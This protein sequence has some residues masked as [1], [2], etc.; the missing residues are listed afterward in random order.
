[1]TVLVAKGMK[2]LPG[3]GDPMVTTLA[4][5]LLILTPLAAFLVLTGSL[6]PVNVPALG[7]FAAAGVSNMM[8]ARQSLFAGIR[9]VG[10]SRAAAVKHFTPVVTIALAWVFLEE[11]LGP[12][13]VAGTA[14]VVG[15]LFLLLL[16]AYASER[17]DELDAR[18][19]QTAGILL[20]GASAIFLGV[21]QALRK[22]GI[23][24]MPDP[25]I[26]AA[27]G[28]WSGA[29]AYS[30][31]TVARR[32]LSTVRDI[33]QTSFRAF[34]LAGIAGTLAPILFLAALQYS[35]VSHVAVIGAS[36]VILTVMLG[37]VL[38]RGLDSLSRRLVIPALM[39]FA[40]SLLIALVR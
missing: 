8:L 33:A 32:Q 1:M 5:N 37:A 35:P 28:A 4:C 31:I 29:I 26:A 11:Q 12:Q 21:G 23:D 34:W 25:V 40:G 2:D 14:L 39:V 22:A 24:L 16:E 10:G 18:S 30:V 27:V 19:G 15:A 36:E 38:V 17:D 7:F 6:S 13:A 3:A 20:A 9:R